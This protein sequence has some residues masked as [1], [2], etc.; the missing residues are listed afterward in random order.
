MIKE[1]DFLTGIGKLSSY[2][3]RFKLSGDW[4]KNKMST[5]RDMTTKNLGDHQKKKEKKKKKAKMKMKM[6]KDEDEKDSRNT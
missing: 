5:T 4:I 1:V 3:K 2:H 6:N